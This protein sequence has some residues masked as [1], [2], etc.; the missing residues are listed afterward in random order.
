M[1]IFAQKY[2]SGAIQASI[3]HWIIF[4]LKLPCI[5]ILDI[6]TFSEYYLC[7]LTLICISQLLKWLFIN[8]EYIKRIFYNHVKIFILSV[9]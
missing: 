3:E 7:L 6:G 5:Y 2:S 1:Y 8:V 9:F 4:S